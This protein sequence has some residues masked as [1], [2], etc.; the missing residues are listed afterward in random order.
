VELASVQT[1]VEGFEVADFGLDIDFEAEQPSMTDT[2]R[3]QMKKRKQW[4]KD[5][6]YTEP[7]CNL[8]DMVEIHALR[9]YKY[10][11]SFKTGSSEGTPI[12]ELKKPFNGLSV[13]VPLLLERL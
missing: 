10:V 1:D 2:M 11:H 9:G 13:D 12:S 5:K 3:E 7:V 4:G 6:D 8:A